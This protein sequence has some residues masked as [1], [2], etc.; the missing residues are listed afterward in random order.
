MDEH[1]KEMQIVWERIRARGLDQTFYSALR[2]SIVDTMNDASTQE[3]SHKIVLQYQLV[4]Q[5]QAIINQ[6]LNL[7]EGNTKS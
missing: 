4:D 2:Q 3:E 1:I 7:D 5:L 6:V